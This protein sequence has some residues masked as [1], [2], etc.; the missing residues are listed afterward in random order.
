[1]PLAIDLQEGRQGHL[2]PRVQAAVGKG[3]SLV[4]SRNGFRHHVSLAAMA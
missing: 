1:M 2:H 3:L 4:S